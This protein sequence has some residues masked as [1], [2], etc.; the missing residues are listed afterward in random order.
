MKASRVILYGVLLV[1]VA[2]FGGFRVL[3]IRADNVAAEALAKREADEAQYKAYAATIAMQRPSEDLALSQYLPVRYTRPASEWQAGEKVFYEKLLASGKADVLVVPFQV[4]GWA[5]DRATRSLMAAQLATALAQSPQLKVADPYLVARALGEGQRRLNQQDIYKLA[6]AIGAKRIIMGYAG[7]DRK[8]KMSVAVLSHQNTGAAPARTGWSGKISSTKYEQIP[9]SD[10]APAIEGYQAL[11]PRLVKALGGEAAAGKPPVESRLDMSALPPSPVNLIA[12]DDNPARDA[13]VFLLYHLLTP[14][15]MERT[16]ERFA[17][18]AL[19]ALSRLAPASP[20]YR[21]LRARTYMALGLRRAA[22][23]TIGAPQTDEEHGLL[24]ALNGNLP[25]VRTMADRQKNPLKHLMQKIDENNIATPYGVVNQKQSLAE[26]AA[27]KLP[28]NIWP[29][30]VGRAFVDSDAWSQHDNASLK[31][32]LD[33]ELPVQGYSLE[34]MARGAMA[35]GDRAKVEA[36]VNLS[37]LEHGRKFIHAD[38]PR[39]C[40]SGAFDRP[41]TLDYLELLQ[42]MGHDNLIRRIRFLSSVQGRPNHAITYA[43]S[44]DAVYRGHPYYAME[45]AKA[46]AKLAT[47][48]SGA[49]KLGLQQ[50]SLENAFNA[51][52][53]EQG[54]SLV[55]NEA[56]EEFN[57]DGGQHFGHAGNLYHADIPF[58]PYYWTWADGGQADVIR[59]NREAALTNATW[60][61][62]A[63][64]K[65]DADSPEEGRGDRLVKSIEGRFLGSPY[66]N[67]LLSKDALRRG[68][69]KTAE[70]L[71]RENIK[72]SPDYWQSYQVLGNLLFSDGEAAEAA[73]VFHT[74]PGFTKGASESRVAI[75]N[76]AYEAGSLFYWSGHFDLAVPFYKIAASQRTGAASEITSNL[77]VKL[78]AGDLGAAMAGTLDRAQRYKD[79]Y[80]QRD[81]LGML[82]ASGRSREAWPAFG[83]L[84]GENH[85]PHVWETALVGHHIAASSEAQVVEWAKQKEFSQAGLEG[86]AAAVYLA[87]FGTTDRVPSSELSAAID[88]LD[89]ELWKVEGAE[90]LVHVRMLQYMRAEAK[91]QRVKS[92]LAYFVEGY[93][94]LKRKDYPAAKSIFDEAAGFYDLAETRKSVPTTFY[95]P[96][97]ALAAAK[98]GVTSGIEKILGGIDLE[99]QRFDYHLAR[100]VLAGASGKTEEALRALELALYRRPHT[101]RR[102]LLTQY[103]YGEIAEVVAELTGSP[104]AREMALDWARKNQKFEPWHSW[105]YA[106]EAKLSSD[107]AGRQRALAMAHYL[108]PQSERLSAFRKSDIDAAV[109][110]FG[111]ANPFPLATQ[112]R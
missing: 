68:D 5:F 82:H 80:A 87:R 89:Y 81:Y 2:V 110:A 75:A 72:L 64:Y 34:E 13:Y 73:R 35:L 108:D 53:W 65:L 50:A 17:E 62:S 45:R 101:E 20:D 105:S 43:N 106:M 92:S 96:Y 30:I 7:H 22:I 100:A 31:M 102:P 19:L 10:E 112:Q 109:K 25:E 24:A 21:V 39:W 14:A 41:V 94:A 37:V 70:V 71:Y 59:A 58:R 6:D 47:E 16:R 98:G 90:G 15:Y 26:A 60:E 95:L 28:G 40:C 18:K 46:E 85:H 74:Y 88:G 42:S 69:T 66:R 93:R 107:P 111:R 63:A 36:A 86:N 52:Y 8:G 79:S 33:Y 97:Y 27:L 103:T 91:R 54:Q 104:K 11:M 84:A 29:Y 1:S 32:L 99:D 49:E 38:A 48:S 55:S 3:Q 4:W 9:F 78:L 44:I 77:R 83:T 12:A 76:Y 56:I 51:F 61:I 57:A 23:K 67:V